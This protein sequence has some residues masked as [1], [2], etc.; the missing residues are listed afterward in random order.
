MKW[1]EVLMDSVWYRYIELER[2]FLRGYEP[3]Y[4]ESRISCHLILSGVSRG[5]LSSRIDL[6]AFHT[7]RSHQQG[8]LQF[9]WGYDGS[10]KREV[11]VRV[12]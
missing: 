9:S 7:R 5:L 1:L 10:Q 3:S 2:Y 11:R 6:H 8:V 4:P 12:E